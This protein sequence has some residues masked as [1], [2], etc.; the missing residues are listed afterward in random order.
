MSWNW[1]KTVLADPTRCY[2]LAVYRA[3]SYIQVP[4][5]STMEKKTTLVQKVVR[6]LKHYYHGFRLLA[7]ETRLS[8]KYMWR[9]LRGDTLSRRERQQLVRFLFFFCCLLLRISKQLCVVVEIWN[10]V[11]K[12]TC[13]LATG[14][15][16]HSFQIRTV[17]D[18]FRLV[19]FSIFIIVPFMEFALPIFIKLFPNMLPSTFQEHSKEVRFAFLQKLFVNSFNMGRW[20]QI[21]IYGVVHVIMV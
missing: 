19:P 3:K 17:S 13:T 2:E 20:K 1:Q 11:V 15:S 10:L 21:V 7:L 16:V 9:V 18:L 14:V 4:V 12:A 5:G 6:E 8:A